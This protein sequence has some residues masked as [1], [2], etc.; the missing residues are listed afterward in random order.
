MGAAV[1]IRFPNA[2]DKGDE[3]GRGRRPLTV[4]AM[5]GSHKSGKLHQLP[6]IGPPLR[7]EGRQRRLGLPRRDGRDVVSSWV[8]RAMEPE[9]RTVTTAWSEW[10][11]WAA[12][13]AAVA[14]VF[15]AVGTVANSASGSLAEAI[16]AGAAAPLYAVVPGVGA[17]WASRRDGPRAPLGLA[18][19]ATWVAVAH[20]PSTLGSVVGG[21]TR[22]LG[23][24][25]IPVGMVAAT[26]VAALLALRDRGDRH[27]LTRPGLRRFTAAA[28]ALWALA[29]TGFPLLRQL[30]WPARSDAL[31]LWLWTSHLVGLLVLLSIAA[32]MWRR[33]SLTMV[34][35][36][37]VVTAAALWTVVAHGVTRATD[38]GPQ[39]ALP[40]LGNPAGSEGGLA[41]ELAAIAVLIAATTR[42]TLV[43]HT[44]WPCPRKDS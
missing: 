1:I 42:L 24:N 4:I 23:A 18:L 36:A 25:L 7:G 21:G 20:L 38:V 39:G 33:A 2:P 10:Q 8:V 34:P 28:I 31:P 5:A 32:V 41:L 14:A 29:A 40:P 16:L 19:V 9:T 43:T 3:G 35:A 37:V 15:G 44:G 30:L 11:R 6:A 26:L 17:W 22:A 12:A 13:L 27:R